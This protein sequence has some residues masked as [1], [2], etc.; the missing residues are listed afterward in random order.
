MQLIWGYIQV[1]L[2]L[3]FVYW[4]TATGVYIRYSFPRYSAFSIAVSGDYYHHCIH[5]TELFRD[6]AGFILSGS[7]DGAGST[8]SLNLS[9][10]FL[11]V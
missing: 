7:L 9:V 1:V 10:R 8:Q 4:I 11:P 2:M 3:I 6:P 5:N